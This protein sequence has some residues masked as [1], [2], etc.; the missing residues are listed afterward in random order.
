M[1]RGPHIADERFFCTLRL[2][3]DANRATGFVIETTDDP[4]DPERFLVTALHALEHTQGL[5]IRF[6]A[7]DDHGRPLLGMSHVV[8][9]PDARPLW[10]AH[11]DERVDVAVMPLDEILDSIARPTY[12]RPIPAH[13]FHDHESIATL[14]AIVDVAFLGYPNGIADPAH[15]TPVART[16]HSA[17]PPVLDFGG[18]PQFLVD[19]SVFPGSSGSPVFGPPP[20]VPDEGPHDWL[21]GIVVSAKAA[22]ATAADDEEEA[23]NLQMLDLGVVFKTPVIDELL[24]EARRR[25]AGGAAP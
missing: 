15:T 7:A 14:P 18:S 17:T 13:R 8:T 6:M 20:G 9:I 2:D 10:I 25:P 12:L 22:P 23:D 21:L 5:T 4:G 3:G 1:D 19:A 11:P 24:D 16:G